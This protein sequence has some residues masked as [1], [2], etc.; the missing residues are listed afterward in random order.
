ME[1][2]EQLLSERGCPKLQL[3]VRR[4][5]AAILGFY[6]ALGYAE[7]EVVTLGKRLIVDD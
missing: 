1:R 6:T 5:N 2:A 3:M 7:A 4:D